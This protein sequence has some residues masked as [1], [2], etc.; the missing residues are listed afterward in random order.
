MKTKVRKIVIGKVMPDE[1]LIDAI[2]L[3]VKKDKIKAGIVNA[4]GA[5]KKF[6]IAYFN[7]D[8]KKYDFRTFDENVELISC[9]GSISYKDEEPVIHLHVTLGRNDYSLIGG[10]LGQPSV[11]SITAEVYIY[12]INQKLN[13]VND[14]R[15]NLALLDL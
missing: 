1:D 2:I 7:L 13:R 8:A 11:I 6:T 4:I 15:F 14:P 10:H 5:F 12:E 9:I 3:I